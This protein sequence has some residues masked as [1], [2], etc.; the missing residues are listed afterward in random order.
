MNNHPRV[1]AETDEYRAVCVYSPSPGDPQCDAPATLHVQVDCD[2]YGVVALAACPQH[3]P[4][5][6]ASGR[7]IEEHVYEG[8]CGLPGTLWSPQ[9][10]CVLDDSGREPARVAEHAASTP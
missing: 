4:I 10:M 5:A 8:Y 1:G 2:P 9:N 7:F 6:R 3:A